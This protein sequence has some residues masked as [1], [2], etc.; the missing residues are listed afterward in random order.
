MLQDA[1]GR[2]EA[3]EDTLG[4]ATPKDELMMFLRKNK[5]VFAW[6]YRDIP[7]VDMSMVEHR[8]N[9]D[10][11]Y[12]S[13]KQKKRRFSQEQ[14]KIVSDEIDRLLEMDAIEP[15]KYPDWLSTVVVV[16]KKNGK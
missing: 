14:N 15:C 12:P 10:L 1:K 2:Y 13:V 6:S 9:I 3:P 7:E 5:D 16:K 11:R 8:L 4:R